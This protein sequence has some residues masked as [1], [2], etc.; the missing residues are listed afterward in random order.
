MDVSGYSRFTSNPI[1]VAISLQQQSNL[2][3]DKKQHMGFYV[4]QMWV[5]FTNICNYGKN[6]CK[7]FAV[8]AI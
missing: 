5:V 1:Y 7:S 6:A 4:G 8:D 2:M 3:N